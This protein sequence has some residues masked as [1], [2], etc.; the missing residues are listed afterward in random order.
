MLNFLPAQKKAIPAPFKKGVNLSGWL[1][2]DTA[3]QVTSNYF[4]KDDFE[5]IKSMGCDAIRLPVHFEHLSSGQKDFV[6]SPKVL[7]ILDKCVQWAE[8]LNLYLIIDNHSSNGSGKGMTA[9]IEKKLAE[10]W[11]QVADRY[12]NASSLIIYEIHNE[13]FGIDRAKWGKVQGR[14]ID[15]IRAI[16]TKHTIVVGGADWNSFNTLELLPKYSDSNLIYTF[17]YYEPM[18]FT[19]CGASWSKGNEKNRNIPFPYSKDRMPKIPG[20]L[21]DWERQNFY[22]YRT[23]SGENAMTAALDKAVEFSI[24]RN[25]PVWCGEFGVYKK[26]VSSGDRAEWYKTVGKYMEE[27]GISRTSWD[28]YNSFG[29]FKADTGL[30]PDDLD[31][32]VVK[33]MGLTVP[34]KAARNIS[35]KERAD[36]TGDYSIYNNGFVKGLLAN[37]WLSDD[38]KNC[39]LE[40]TDSATGETV[41]DLQTL[42]KYKGFWITFP[43]GLRLLKEM[44]AG[45]LIEF[46]A[47]TGEQDLSYS[48][49]FSNSG[50]NIE[51]WRASASLEKSEIPAD[52]GW[53]KIRIPLKDMADIGA[54]NSEK[55]V[56]VNSA[57][58]FDWNDIV[59]LHFE[60]GGSDITKGLCFRNIR[61][62]I[63]K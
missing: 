43:G 49:Y 41:I 6:I 15:L 35:W 32:A 24:K 17:H 25:A 16:D 3:G 51:K 58:L 2:Q 18:L 8:D 53:H 9:D 29:P 20:G 4:T 52:G 34:P 27:R 14:T 11:T 23:A 57:G 26:F 55:S 1:E 42:G 59:E 56:W 33:G 60:N 30:F 36:R 22:N 61:L 5:N 37:A 31:E 10:I 40:K 46:E 45:A 12:K 13:P 38:A 50:K 7:A 47:K 39:D 28:Y 62:I 44:E 19:H 63:K 54:W 48:I 21:Q